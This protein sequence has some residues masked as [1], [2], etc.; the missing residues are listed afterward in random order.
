MKIVY[1]LFTCQNFGI[2]NNW[3]IYPIL[4]TGV[5]ADFVPRGKCP[6][7]QYL[8]AYIVL[9]SFNASE[10]RPPGQNPLA[11]MV[12]HHGFCSTLHVK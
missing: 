9:R 4:G 12:Q 1:L 3:L 8:L 5:P 11:E 6:V 7:G 2:Y 10:K